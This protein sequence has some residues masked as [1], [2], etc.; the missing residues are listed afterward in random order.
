RVELVSGAG[1]YGHSGKAVPVRGTL[2][3]RGASGFA[4]L[5]VPKAGPSRLAV[6]EVDAQGGSSEAFSTEVE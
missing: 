2:F 3:A 4:R 6:L 5:D 1:I